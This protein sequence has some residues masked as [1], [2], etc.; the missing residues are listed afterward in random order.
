MFEPQKL[1]TLGLGV[2]LLAPFAF[3][4]LLIARHQ[5]RPE[6]EVKAQLEAELQRSVR[7]LGTVQ[8][9]GSIIGGIA[10]GQFEAMG[11]SRGTAS[12][13]SFFPHRWVGILGL[14]GVVSVFFC[15]SMSLFFRGGVEI[16][17]SRWATP[18]SNT[19]Q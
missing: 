7:D 10:V 15:L 14:F 8:P 11:F 19:N 4:F 12:W 3:V 13:L 2:V 17:A 9:D 16:G 6:A 18:S 1:I 5:P